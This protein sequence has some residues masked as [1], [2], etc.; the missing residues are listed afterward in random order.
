MNQRELQRIKIVD[1]TVERRITT[2][3]APNSGRA[4]R[5]YSTS[6]PAGDSDSSGET[7]DCVRPYS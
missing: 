5:G 6:I 7:G 4:A 1:N 2:A 3:A